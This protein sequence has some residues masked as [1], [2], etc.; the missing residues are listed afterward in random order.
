MNL[1][2]FDLCADFTETRVSHEH[3]AKYLVICT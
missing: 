3:R 1:R 2:E